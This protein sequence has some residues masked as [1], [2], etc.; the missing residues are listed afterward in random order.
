MLEAR[1]MCTKC[2]GYT[3][4]CASCLFEAQQIVKSILEDAE[5]ARTEKEFVACGARAAK[6]TGDQKPLSADEADEIL[7]RLREKT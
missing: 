1:L 2:R 6:Y 3:A 4:P 5:R 7:L